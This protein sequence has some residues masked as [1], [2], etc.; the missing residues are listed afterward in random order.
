M[1]NGVTAYRNDA[2]SNLDDRLNEWVERMTQNYL[3]AFG[4]RYEPC[5][6]NIKIRWQ[7]DA[8]NRIFATPNQAHNPSPNSEILRL[9]HPKVRDILSRLP[10]FVPG[11]LLENFA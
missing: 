10:R 4:G 1:K 2:K 3:E 11:C 7:G 5:L 8:Q 6:N 9:D